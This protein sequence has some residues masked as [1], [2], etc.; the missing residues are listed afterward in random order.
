[1]SSNLSNERLP[2]AFGVILPVR[3]KV[4]KKSSEANKFIYKYSLE[5]DEKTH[6]TTPIVVEKVDI[7]K[8]VQSYKDECGLEAAMRLIKLGRASP[9]DFC[10]DG[11]HGFDITQ[12]PT[13]AGDALKQ[14]EPGIKQ[15]D[16]LKKLLGIPAS[17]EINSDNLDSIVSLYVKK[18]V[19][20]TL[21]ASQA[22]N[23]K[24]GNE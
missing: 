16:T 1:M 4:E 11:K 12:V 9:E 15:A 7:C 20:E 17:V 5:V 2:D 14:L 3:K 19:D 13:F 10:D 21:A 23:S 24:G 8:L 6:R 18:K 22:D